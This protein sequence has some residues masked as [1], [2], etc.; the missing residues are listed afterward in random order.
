MTFDW[1]LGN[2]ARGRKR[3]PAGCVASGAGQDRLSAR[4]PIRAAAGSLLHAVAGEFGGKR[5]GVQ[6]LG[7]G[8]LDG[9][10]LFELRNLS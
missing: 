3:M 6:C 8:E 1:T 5:L 10:P 2:D 4:L 9:V 7:P